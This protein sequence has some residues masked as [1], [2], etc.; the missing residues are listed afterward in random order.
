M[1]FSPNPEF[2]YYR[3]V[4]ELLVGLKAQAYAEVCALEEKTNIPEPD[5]KDKERFCYWAGEKEGPTTRPFFTYGI[6]DRREK[7]LTPSVLITF[8]LT[9]FNFYGMTSAI[10]CK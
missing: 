7:S 10:N 4:I 9:H 3:D 8:F 2:L 1:S 6:W 5:P